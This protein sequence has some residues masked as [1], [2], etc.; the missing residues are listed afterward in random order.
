MTDAQL[1]K[2][3]ATYKYV[4]KFQLSPLHTYLPRY[5]H[6]VHFIGAYFSG[7][8]HRYIRFHTDDNH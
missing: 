2:D 5:I 7:D 8:I 6:V 1:G 3:D 4:P